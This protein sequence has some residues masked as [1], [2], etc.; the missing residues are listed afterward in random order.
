[1]VNPDERNLQEVERLSIFELAGNLFGLDILKSREVI[2]LPRYTP[3]PNSEDIFC[4]VFNLR[5]EIFPLVDISPILGLPLK[6]I[7]SE[8]MVILVEVENSFVF[9]IIVDKIHSVLSYTLKEL[10]KPQGLVSKSME[11][12]VTGILHLDKRMIHT[13]DVEGLFRTR[14]ILAHY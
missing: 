8:D 7:K 3:L 13:L 9:G 1:M 6:K 10:K 4:G 14:Q 2:P 12:F 11:S 5:G